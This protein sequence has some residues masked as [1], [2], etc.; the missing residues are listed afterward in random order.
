MNTDQI[1]GRVNSDGN[2]AIFTADG[3]AVTRLDAD[4]YPVGSDLGCRYEH[5]AGIVLSKLDTNKLHITIE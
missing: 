4:C 3:D 5:P 2:V 1:F